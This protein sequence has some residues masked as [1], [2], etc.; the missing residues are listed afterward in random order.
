MVAEIVSVGTEL[1]MGQIVDTNS[2]YISKQLS[3]LGIAV[4][5]KSTVGDNPARMR[6][7]IG[8][9]LQRSD[10]VI[11]TGG[12]GPTEDD[13]TKETVAEFLG[14]PLYMNQDCLK[15]LEERMRRFHGKDGHIPQI[16]RK[17]AMI[18]ETAIV[19]PNPNGTAPGCIMQKDGKIAIVMPGPPF[20]MKPMFENYARPFLADQCED[21]MESH[22]VHTLGLGESSV[23]EM[24]EDLIQHQTNPTL[25][26]YI[27]NADV[28]VRITAKCK[29]GED[30]N[31]IIRPVEEEVVR[32]LG[33]YVYTVGEE[34][35]EDVV[36]RM[37]IDRQKTLAVA[38]S[39]TGGWLAS[40]LV[41]KDGASKFL[42]EGIVSYSNEAK[43]RLLN[44]PKQMLDAHGAVSEQVA[45]AMAENV[46]T[47]SGADYGLSTTGIA[48]PGGGTPEKPVGTVYVAVAD[49][50]GC[51]VKH[52]TFTSDR[53]RNRARAISNVLNLLRLR[54]LR[55]E[56]G[57]A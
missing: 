23:A 56:E 27:S 44:V 5:Y 54:M 34:P 28:M 41:H 52:Y 20:E 11:T 3:D 37:L 22:Y 49:A 16:N 43:M 18:P 47:L 19:M 57:R 31:A 38:E 51:E 50:N 46:R 48:G 9:A 8:Q 14:L 17:Q 25:A 35:L 36:A 6:E 42:L 15:A 13:I 55:E 33:A 29:K 7:V 45:R 32:R 10:V 4:Y 21:V 39:C 12:L 53:T 30:P 40:T 2:Q 24:L 1:L 26:T